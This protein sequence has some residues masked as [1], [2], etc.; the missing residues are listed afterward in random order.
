M[1][2]LPHQKK[3]GTIKLKHQNFP[4]PPPFEY[5]FFLGGGAFL[6]LILA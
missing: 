4:P 6:F 1:L 5:V 3:P 2:A